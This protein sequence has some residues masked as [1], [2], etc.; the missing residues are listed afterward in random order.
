MPETLL[1]PHCRAA[2]PAPAQPQPFGFDC[3]QCNRTIPA[4]ATV[5]VTEP[6]RDYDEF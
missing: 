5:A 2:V 4:D 6:Q 1:C 3:P